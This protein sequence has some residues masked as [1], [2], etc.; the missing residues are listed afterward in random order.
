MRLRFQCQYLLDAGAPDFEQLQR[1]ALVAG[2]TIVPRGNA[3]PEG[4]VPLG[5][6]VVGGVYA[7]PLE[8]DGVRGVGVLDDQPLHHFAR[9]RLH[10]QDRPVVRL[11][12]THLVRLA[13]GVRMERSRDHDGAVRHAGPRLDRGILTDLQPGARSLRSLPW[14]L[15]VQGEPDREQHAQARDRGKESMGGWRHGS[16]EDRVAGGARV[17]DLAC[18]FSGAPP[19]QPSPRGGGSKANEKAPRMRR[20]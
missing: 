7:D 12:V 13:G 5:E 11:H 3:Q 17:T 18:A 2:A 14:R 8:G 6:G 9:A 10:E 4:A 15:W 19:P 16:F 1:H 20:F